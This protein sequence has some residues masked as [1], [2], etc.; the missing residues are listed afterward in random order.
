MIR[1]LIFLH[2]WLGIAFG[3]LFALWFASGIVMHFVPYPSLTAAD[4]RAGLAPIDLAQVKTSPWEALA[5]SQIGNTVRVRL[6]QRSDGPIYLV[7]NLSRT[8][9]LHAADLSEAAVVS[10]KLARAIALDY[11]MR[12]QWHAPAASIA[13]LQD[14]DQWTLPAELDPYRPL[15]RVALNDASET[16]LYVSKTTGEVVLA[17]THRQRAWNYAGSV[18][19][20]IYLTALRTHPIVWS[21]LLWWLSLLALIGAT[22]GACIGILRIEVRGSRLM[23]PYAGL[24]AWHHWLGLGCSLFVLTW[25]L[26]GWLSM[27]DGTLFSPDKPSDEAIAAATGAPDWSVIPHD[28][29]QHLDPRTIEAE[30]FAFGGDI[31]CRQIHRHDQWLDI[32]DVASQAS[33]GER[34]LLDGEEIN[35][36]ARR[37]APSCAPA[38]AIGNDEA[39]APAAI[40]PETQVFRLICGDDWFDIDAANGALL[41]KLDR[42]RRAYRWLSGRLHRLDFPVLARHPV[43]QTC[44]IVVLCGCGFI[45]SLTGVVIGWRRLWRVAGSG[46][47]YGNGADKPP[48]SQSVM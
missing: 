22:L 1:A 8:L 27:D 43:V 47:L 24:H 5:A 45:F 40:L 11:A 42:S 9:A 32:A 25:L 6:V 48:R 3:L 38:V 34:A 30:W 14:Y 29:A 19:H 16:D 4:R 10:A 46:V 31:Y 21:R 44:L 41:D 35:A 36:T 7:S 18:A 26:S 20:W 15:Y 13:A 17:T 37:L 33:T 12:R 23:S 28:E 2:R 39:Y